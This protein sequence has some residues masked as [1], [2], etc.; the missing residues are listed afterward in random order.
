MQAT[1]LFYGRFHVYGFKSK[2]HRRGFVGCRFLVQRGVLIGGGPL[3]LGPVSPNGSQAVEALEPRK[4]GR[5]AGLFKK[6]V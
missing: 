3:L 6:L 5:I 1:L 4:P 2:F